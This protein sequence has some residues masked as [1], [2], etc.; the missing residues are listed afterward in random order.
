M[1]APITKILLCLALCLALFL[2][3]GCQRCIEDQDVA[4]VDFYDLRKNS[5]IDSIVM[6]ASN[7]DSIVGCKYNLFNSP[8]VIVVGS[9]THHVKFPINIRLQL[10]S[11]GDL[12]KELF[13]EIDKKMLSKI[14]HG[15]GCSGFSGNPP[16]FLT[17]DYCLYI[18]NMSDFPG[19]NYEIM[20]CVEL[21]TDG[22]HDICG[23]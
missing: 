17:D 5:L 14:S 6:K 20:S 12:L 23:M 11:Q 10:F 16:I 13:F 22:K 2:S 15:A 1:F 4:R 7:Y 18:D 9:K 8:D 3:W 19:Y 21:S